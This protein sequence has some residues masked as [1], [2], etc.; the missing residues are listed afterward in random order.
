MYHIYEH[1][2]NGGYD[3]VGV[4]DDVEEIRSALSQMDH[5]AFAVGRDGEV[6]R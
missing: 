5:L 2:G 1:I 4:S 3:V 6:I